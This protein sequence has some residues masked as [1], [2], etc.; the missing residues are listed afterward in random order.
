MFD[1]VEP[2]TKSW[3]HPRLKGFRSLNPYLRLDLSDGPE[4]ISDRSASLILR[5][6][7]YGQEL[8]ASDDRAAK[9]PARPYNGL[10]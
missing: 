4:T 3:G 8:N 5:A 7:K 2:E 10:P 6:I 9:T 1:A